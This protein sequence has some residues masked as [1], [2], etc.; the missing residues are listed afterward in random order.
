VD[1]QPG[2]STLLWS[3]QVLSR[4]G[5]VVA[6]SGVVFIAS[7]YIVSGR[8]RWN[9]Q[10][11][12][13]GLAIFTVIVANAASTGLLLAGRRSIGLRRV[14]LLGQAA[15]VV[16]RAPVWLPQDS[17]TRAPAALVGGDGLKRYHRADCTMSAGRQWQVATRLEHE[18]AGRTPCGLCRP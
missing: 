14:E 8:A 3:P 17:A 7:W 18:T 4:W 1:Q 13:M 5:S 10:I 12:A 16:E 11:P 2:H 15:E 9:D 6:L